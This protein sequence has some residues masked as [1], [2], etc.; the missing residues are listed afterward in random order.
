[1]LAF[2]F[3]MALLPAPADE[4]PAKAERFT[5][6][7]TGL[8]SPDREKDLRKSFEEL[9]DFT[10]VSIDFAEAEITVAFVPSKVFP[11][12]KPERIVELVS[13]K[14][15]QTSH[16]TF[17]VKP[18]RTVPRDKLQTVEIV[19]AGLDC[20]GC[21]LAAYEAI[22]GIDGVEQATASF[23]EGRVTA[24]I[25]PTKTDRAKLEDALRKKGVAVGKP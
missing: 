10:L 13:E 19:A 24:L 25:D 5:Y 20:K 15:G 9:T 3:V 23:K 1:M 2:C 8:F 7:I 17:G 11:N 12:Q 6:R 21:S 4:K 16:H 18:K 14:L 22:S